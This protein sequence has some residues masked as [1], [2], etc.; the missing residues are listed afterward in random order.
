VGRFG[1][2]DRGGD[3]RDRLAYYLGVGLTLWTAWQAFTG[4]SRWSGPD[5][6]W[7]SGCGSA[8]PQASR[9]AR[10]GVGAMRDALVLVVIGLGT[11]AYGRRSS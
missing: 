11:Y 2:P 8:R 1:R 7:G 6:R 10:S 5:C 3:A 9:P 4:A